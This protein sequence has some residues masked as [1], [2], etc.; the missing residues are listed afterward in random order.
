MNKKTKKL[1]F[2][3]ASV[4][5]IFLVWTLAVSFI[6]V[7]AVGP[8]NSEVGFAAINKLFHN[9]TGVNF[10][11][12]TITDWLGLV[13]IAFAAGFGILG[14]VQSIKRR[15]IEK[16]D[17]NLIT[18]GVFYI[19]TIIFYLLFEEIVINYR[20][21]LINGYLEPSYPSSTT[22]LVATI[23]PTAIMQFNLRI[24]NKYAKRI[25]AFIIV[26]FMIFMIGGRL[27]SGVHWLTDILGGLLLSTSLVLLLIAVNNLKA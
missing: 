6:D 21:V 25:I 17:F 23:M 12:Y 16:V 1:I 10:T 22:L 20:P 11:L 5:L 27:I 4:F 19:I 3:S 9:I 15:R 24:K 2:S 18:L 8:Y 14:L 13:P 7:K 26:L